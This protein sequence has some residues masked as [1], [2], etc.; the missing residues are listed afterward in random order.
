MYFMNT[1]ANILS[2]KL[3]NQISKSKIQYFQVGLILGIQD[4]L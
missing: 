1:D 4:W 3:V 2:K